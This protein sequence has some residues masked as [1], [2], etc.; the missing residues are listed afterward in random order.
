MWTVHSTHVELKRDWRIGCLS[1]V[2]GIGNGFG[3]CQTNSQ[4]IEL[5][6]ANKYL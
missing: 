2:C 3:K 6:N 5:F 1:F 4:E